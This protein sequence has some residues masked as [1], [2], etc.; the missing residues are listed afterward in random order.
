M[1]KALKD[2]F[3]FEKRGLKGVVILSVMLCLQ[4]LILWLLNYY[5]PHKE[6]KP[7]LV[8]VD[9]ALLDSLEL[10]SQRSYE[11]A[12]SEVYNE[13]VV[14]IHQYKQK[15]QRFSFNPNNV[16]NEQWEQLGLSKYQVKSVR[17]YIDRGGRFKKPEDVLKIKVVNPELWK[18][19]IPYIEIPHGENTLASKSKEQLQTDSLANNKKLRELERQKMLEERKKNLIFDFNTCNRYNL[20]M[21]DLLDSLTIEKIMR[22]KKAIGG[23]VSL[24]QLYEIEQIDTNNFTQLKS[25]LTLDLMSLRTI[26]I[27]TCN[28]SQLSKHPYVS[29]NTAVALVNYRKTHGKYAQLSDLKKCIATN[30]ALLKKIGPYLRFND[31]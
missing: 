20:E 17:K 1:I 21:L 27:N 30:E 29:Y 2:F 24:N 8:T 14:N 6:V 22:Y 12:A 7:N 19:L 9:P 25:H 13:D 16:S 3:T 11:P 4:L 31:D 10:Y 18:D 5:H 28:A 15:A 23:F 26:N